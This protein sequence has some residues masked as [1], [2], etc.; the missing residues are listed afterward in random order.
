MCLKCLISTHP[1]KTV[2]FYNDD[3]EKVSFQT[4]IIEYDI[5]LIEMNNLV[6]L[7]YSQGC[8]FSVPT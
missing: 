6:Y 3:N 4:K 5:C 2:L 7:Q 8:R 1:Q